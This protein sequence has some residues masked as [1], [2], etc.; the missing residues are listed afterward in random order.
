M[1]CWHVR[2]SVRLSVRPSV[3]TLSGKWLHC[4][5]LNKTWYIDRWQW[6]EMKNRRTIILPCIC[7]ELSPLN[8]LFFHPGWLSEPYLGKYTMD[9]DKTW[10]IDRWQWEKVKWTRTITIPFI[11]LSYLPVTIL[12]ILVA[13]P[14]HILE[15]TI[16]VE[17]KLGTYIY[18]NERE[19]RRQE[20]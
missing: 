10:F 5:H 18:V 12:F 17:I 4:W 16:G 8:Y 6:R 1:Q 2:P 15:S 11:V 19:Y 13:Y 14:G 7:V 20:P 3:R 9:W